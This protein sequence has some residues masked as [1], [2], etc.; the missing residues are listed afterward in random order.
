MAPLLFVGVPLMRMLSCSLCLRSCPRKKNRRRHCTQD[1]TVLPVREGNGQRDPASRSVAMPPED[2]T[3]LVRPWGVPIPIASSQAMRDK[4]D[5]CKPRNRA[6][7]RSRG[8]LLTQTR[9]NENM[10]MDGRHRSRHLSPRRF[11][12]TSPP[13]GGSWTPLKCEPTGRPPRAGPPRP[14]KS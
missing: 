1:A 2:L 14:K 5:R 11:P 12:P 7:T 13:L 9:T 4:N 10:Q 6:H 3:A 8:T